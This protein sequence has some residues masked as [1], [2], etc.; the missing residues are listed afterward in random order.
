MKRRARMDL[1][2]DCHYQVIPNR[3]HRPFQPLPIYVDISDHLS[4]WNSDPNRERAATGKIQS[5]S[6]PTISSLEASNRRKMVY[7][8]SKRPFLTRPHSS[9]T[10]ALNQRRNT[11]IFSRSLPSPF[12]SSV[13]SKLPTAVQDSVPVTGYSELCNGIHKIPLAAW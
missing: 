9:S 8:S 4:T 7:G 12:H 1:A 11:P 5:P 10:R 13:I 2:R 6:S 3:L